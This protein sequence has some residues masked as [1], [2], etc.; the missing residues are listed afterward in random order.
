M[1]ELGVDAKTFF[2]SPEIMGKE[3]VQKIHHKLMDQPLIDI[4]MRFSPNFVGVL[5]SHRQ[6]LILNANFFQSI[7]FP[8]ED[9][10]YGFRPGEIL[11]CV[12]F[13]WSPSG[14][15]TAKGCEFCGIIKT[16]LQAIRTGKKHSDEAILNTGEGD[17]FRSVILEVTAEPVDIDGNQVIILFLKDIRDTKRKEFLE[18]LFFHDIKNSLHSLSGLLQVSQ[19][20]P[21]TDQQIPGMIGNIMEDIIDQIH[22][23]QKLTL[24]HQ[25]DLVLNVEPFE[26]SQQIKNMVESYLNIKGRRSIEIGISMDLVPVNI[27]SDPVIVRR[28]ILNM[29]KNAYEACGKGDEIKLETRINEG[30]LQV[31]VYNSVIIPPHVQAQI[32]QQTFSTKGK[33]RGLGTYGMKMLSNRYLQGDVTFT[34]QEGSGTIFILE[35]PLELTTEKN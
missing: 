16:V 31:R 11:R 2:A 24:A 9:S 26:I 5:N 10:V 21:E 13:Q 4:L 22:Y 12:H 34:S 25:N 32:F 30:K 18:R 6:F 14:C 19:F 1:E 15:G 8:V 27:Y 17:D 7:D 20:S 23:H 3:E 29:F 33:G 35:L 28:I